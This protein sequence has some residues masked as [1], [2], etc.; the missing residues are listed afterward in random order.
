MKYAGPGHYIMPD[1]LEVGNGLTSVEDT[2]HFSLWAMLAAPLIS[3]NDLT[4][5]TQTTLDI[6]TNTEVIV[7]DQ[8]SMGKPCQLVSGCAYLLT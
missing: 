8:D 4:N 2:T 3:G 5:M 1:I 7:V 6:L